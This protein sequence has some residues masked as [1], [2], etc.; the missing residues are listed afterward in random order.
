MAC[1]LKAIADPTRRTMLRSFSAAAELP[2]S[3]ADAVRLEPIVRRHLHVLR[4]AGLLVEQPPGAGAPRYRLE[5][6][7][8]RELAA[9]LRSIVDE[10]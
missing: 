3:G 6:G 7:G 5:R 4:R 8:L 10:A 1:V 9:F 2:A